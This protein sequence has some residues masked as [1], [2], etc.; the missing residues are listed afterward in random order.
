MTAPSDTTPTPVTQSTAPKPSVTSND[1]FVYGEYE[2]EANWHKEQ[3]LSLVLNLN[4]YINVVHF[5]LMFYFSV[6]FIQI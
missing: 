6:L 1:P 3:N 4:L 2:E 5:N